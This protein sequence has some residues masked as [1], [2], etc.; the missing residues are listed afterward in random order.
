M[1]PNAPAADAGG[2]DATWDPYIVTA[3]CSVQS[4]DSD[5]P[6]ENIRVVVDE[7]NATAVS[8]RASLLNSNGRG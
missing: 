1:E 2:D 3:V 6:S 7:L 4:G 5:Y 8:R